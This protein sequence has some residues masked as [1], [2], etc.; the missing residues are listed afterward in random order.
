MYEVKPVVVSGPSQL[1][2]QGNLQAGAISLTSYS[3]HSKN[4]LG[5]FCS[6]FG[7][8]CESWR[9]WQRSMIRCDCGEVR[10][11]A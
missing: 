7:E 11:G 6:L 4:V 9:W 8:L 5:D 3:Y 2:Q 1:R 10:N